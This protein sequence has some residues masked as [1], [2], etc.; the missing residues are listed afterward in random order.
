VQHY[1][2]HTLKIILRLLEEF[3]IHPIGFQAGNI[4]KNGVAA[5]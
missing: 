4:G 5:E 3:R 1:P 2:G